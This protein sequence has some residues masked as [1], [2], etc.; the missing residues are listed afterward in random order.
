M[1][2]VEEIKEA[3]TMRDVLDM[4]GIKVNHNNMC[5]CPIH[6]EKHPSMKVYKDGYHCFACGSNGDI[7]SF[8]QSVEN[9]D[10]KAA[11]YKLGGSYDNSTPEAKIRLFRAQKRILQREK[12]KNRDKI[13]LLTNGVDIIVYGELYRK[14]IPDSEEFWEYLEKYHS[15]VIREENILAGIQKKGGDCN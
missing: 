14:A 7:F 15:A 3:Y 6:G 5:C 13:E 11:F 10:F 8:V 4:Y 9:C 12:E 2:T 1:A